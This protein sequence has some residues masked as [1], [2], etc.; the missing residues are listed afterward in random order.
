MKRSDRLKLQSL[1]FDAAS[2]CHDYGNEF[3]DVAIDEGK[4]GKRTKILHELQRVVDMFDSELGQV[5]RQIN[6]FARNVEEAI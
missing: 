6:M 4:H 5:K 3:V 2:I 1:M